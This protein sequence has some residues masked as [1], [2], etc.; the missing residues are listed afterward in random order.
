[1]MSLR[2]LENLSQ[3]WSR[4]KELGSL[5]PA[6]HKGETMSKMERHTLLKERREVVKVLNKAH[7]RHVKMQ[8][9]NVASFY[10]YLKYKKQ[11]SPEKWL[12]QSMYCYLCWETFDSYELGQ[13]HIKLGHG[14][15]TSRRLNEKAHTAWGNKLKKYLGSPGESTRL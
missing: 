11:L 2:E 10:K 1:M 5:S 9:Y 15:R 13:L 8:P 14:Y 7:I 12:I 3:W 4:P 6:Y